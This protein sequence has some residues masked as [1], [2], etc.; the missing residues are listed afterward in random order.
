MLVM[1]ATAGWDWLCS[2]HMARVECCH[3]QFLII[4]LY[5]DTTTTTSAT[6]TTHSTITTTATI[7]LPPLLLILPLPLPVHTALSNNGYK[8]GVALY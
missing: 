4:L 2:V 6:P 5:C 3:A 7:I 1:A 8:V